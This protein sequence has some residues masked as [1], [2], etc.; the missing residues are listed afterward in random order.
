[1]N[2]LLG[3]RE[4]ARDERLRRDDRR[5]GGQTDERQQRPLRR[6]QEERLFGSGRIAQQERSLA[7]IVQE[8]CR[9]HQAE[10]RDADW[11]LSEVA[12]VGIERFAAGHDEEDRAEHCEAVPAV[13]AEKATAW[14]GIDRRQHHRVLHERRDPERGDHDEPDHHNR[15]EHPADAVRAVPL[16]REHP[17]QDDD[18]D[19][20]HVRIEERGRHLQPFDGTEHCD[21]RRDHPVAVE[22]RRAEESHQHQRRPG[23]ALAVV[24]G[25]QRSQRQDAALALVVGAHDDRDVLDRDDE[26]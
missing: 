25:Q 23:A 26:E 19:Q 4:R 14:R 2:R 7:E 13:L 20:H 1:L 24:L 11:Q 18:R 21:G 12:Y 6:E 22:Q 8:Q 5:G 17:D 10:P 16:D 9:Q 15:S 3:Q